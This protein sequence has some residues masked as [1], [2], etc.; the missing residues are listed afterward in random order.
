MLDEF[1]ATFTPTV[2]AVLE[3]QPFSQGQ[4]VLRE[5]NCILKAGGSGISPEGRRGRRKSRMVGRTRG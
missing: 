2:K 1:T 3:K 5:T 4:V